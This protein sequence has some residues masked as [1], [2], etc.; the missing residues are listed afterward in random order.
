M[1]LTQALMLSDGYCPTAPDVC[2]RCGNP[3]T[4]TFNWDMVETSCMACFVEVLYEHN[5]TFPQY[6][7]Y[8]TDRQQ[9]LQLC[10]AYQ[11]QG[12]YFP[13]GP[14][15]EPSLFFGIDISTKPIC[16]AKGG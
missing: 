7:K 2:D 6:L 11:F 4:L 14:D 12:R 10:R 9:L 3:T 16:Q 15:G 13:Y 5:D 8:A 1:N